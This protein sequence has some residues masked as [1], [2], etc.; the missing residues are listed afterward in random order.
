MKKDD[1]IL[2]RQYEKMI[3][4]TTEVTNWRQNTNNFYLAV[5]TGILAIATYLYGSS[6]GTGQVISLIGIAISALWHQNI[7]YYRTLNA[8]KFKVIHEMERKLPIAAFTKEHEYFKE[9]NTRNATKIEQRIPYLFATAYT[10][11]LIPVILHF[12]NIT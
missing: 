8:A 1:E 10:I 4:T 9:S 2:L 7:C 12:L 3:D 5:N 11:A 6:S